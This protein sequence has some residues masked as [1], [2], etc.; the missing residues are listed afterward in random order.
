MTT[1]STGNANVTCVDIATAGTGLGNKVGL[2]CLCNGAG[3]N[4]AGQF[5]ANTSDSTNNQPQR[6]IDVQASSAGPGAVVGIN[7]AVTGAG[8][9]A[10]TG[11]TVSAS[12][13]GTLTAATFTGN[14]TI[15]GSLSK[16]SGTFLIDHPLDPL[17]KILRHSFVESPEE[18]CLYR[19]KV[20][21]D[22]SGKAKVELPDY[23]PLLTIEE[24]AT[25][26]LAAIGRKPFL[27]SYE[28]NGD[29]T[30]FTVFG[31]PD[32]EVSYLVLANRDDPVIH[33][34]RRPVEEEK[35]PADRNTLIFPDAYPE[36]VKQGI[37]RQG[38]ELHEVDEENEAQTTH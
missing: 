29:F 27:A 28:W 10:K 35:D 18:L 6:G 8:T 30:S 34:L 25:V 36:L 13:T 14:V 12:G 5:N 2:N 19:G 15:S 37:R 1:S 24:Q 32:R 20:K 31:D 17:N 26:T 11:L 3:R 23:F 21:L 38:S 7:I 4:F 9:G 22:K 33:L 16:G